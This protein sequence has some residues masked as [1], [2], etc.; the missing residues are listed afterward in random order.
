VFERNLFIVVLFISLAMAEVLAVIASGM[1]VVSLAIQVAENISKLKGFYDL[2]QN[3]PED[4]QL[5]LDE[6]E[7]LSLILEDIDRS[8]QQE[9]FLSP[10]LKIAVMKSLRL[11]QVSGEALRSLAKDMESSVM[12]G[13]RRGAFKFAMKKDKVDL[14]KKKV[15]SAKSAMLLANQ[16]YNQ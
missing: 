14:F 1:S 11:C 16:C 6:V 5:A 15:D 2:M 4:V 9:L 8:L 3:A 10:S 13:K 7:V 12:T